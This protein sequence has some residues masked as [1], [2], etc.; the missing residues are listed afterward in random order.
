MATGFTLDTSSPYPWIAKNKDASLPYTLDW[1]AWLGADTISA[2]TWTV[3]AGLTKA[4]QTNTPT[5][6][7]AVLSAGTA[8]TAYQV[9]CKIT[10]AAGLVDERTIE[11][12]VEER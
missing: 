10:T 9:G 8:G 5:T 7:S 3:P 11:I 6:A 1:S 2:V 12:R 4:S